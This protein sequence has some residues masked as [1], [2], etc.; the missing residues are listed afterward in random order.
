MFSPASPNPYRLHSP[1][2]SIKTVEK[3]KTSIF[4][5][6][7]SS[8]T[9]AMA[10]TLEKLQNDI[11]GLKLIVSALN[12]K[13]AEFKTELSNQRVYAESLASSIDQETYKGTQSTQ[14]YDED[15]KLQEENCCYFL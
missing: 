1:T 13:I 6:T 7:K 9:Q 11:E 3:A 8:K 15:H 10:V 12:H 14:A 4:G 2:T 5:R